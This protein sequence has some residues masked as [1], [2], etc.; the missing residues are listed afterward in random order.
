M[1]RAKKPSPTFEVVLRGNATP[2]Q[3]PLRTVSEALA[4]IQDI[5]SG[6]DPYEQQSVPDELAIGL[7]DIAR[8]SAI[9][10]CVARDPAAA[11]HNISWAGN[12]L[13]SQDYDESES[14]RMA[15]MLR[16]LAELSKIAK[17]LACEV[18][19]R[20]SKTEANLLS[21]IDETYSK[22][23]GKVLVQGD[24]TIVGQV[25]RAG[26]ATEMKCLLRVQGRRK[27][28]YCDVKN[29]DLVR[30]LG[31]HLYE[32]IAATGTATWIHRTWRVQSFEIHD[33]TQPKLGPVD[34][35][36]HS[37]RTAGLSEWDTICDPK[38]YLERCGS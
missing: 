38:R 32:D 11:L 25:E 27:L 26:G 3:L 20:V 10:R 8:G 4:A 24:T 18:A 37:L 19:V 9:F 33:F 30:R 36:I 17:S 7:L 2:E 14:D 13:A 5:A 12:L 23:A 29:K 22:I 16:P 6:R 21:V 28:L 1:R 34:A 31:Q 15:S 35:M